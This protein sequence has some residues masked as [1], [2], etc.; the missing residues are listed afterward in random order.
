MGP[1]TKVRSPRDASSRLHPVRSIAPGGRSAFAVGVARAPIH[2]PRSAAPMTPGVGDVVNARYE[3]LRELGGDRTGRVFVAA[4]DHSTARWPCGWSMPGT[5]RRWRPC[6]GRR[7]TWGPSSSAPLRRCPVLDE[8]RDRG[9]HRL[10]R[11]RAHRR[12]D[13]R[14][15]RPAARAAARGRGREVRRRAARRVPGGAAGRA[16]PD[17]HRAGLGHRD[18][19]RA[20]ARDA[21]RG[22]SPGSGRHRAPRVRRG[23]PDPAPA[24]GG[25]RGAA[26]PPGRDRRRAQR[27]DRHHRGA[28]GPG[29]RGRPGPRRRP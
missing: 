20:R 19:R 27:L 11:Q 12:P 21:L 8:G 22:G 28:A 24:A 5:A 26:S 7:A 15:A 9:R 17:R 6:A 23:G 10:R 1:V 18:Q 3:L 14:A 25:R 29:R 4:T 13:G 2:P 16:G